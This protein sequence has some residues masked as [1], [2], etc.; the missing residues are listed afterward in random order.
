M[1]SDFA[2]VV[3]SYAETVPAGRVTTYGSIADAIGRGSARNV[4]QVMSAYGREV[5]WWRVVR[6]NGSLPSFLMVDAQEHWIEEHTP[7]RGGAVDLTLALWP[8]F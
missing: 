2:E 3:L 8:G 4:G 6:A 5:P 7:M 1:L